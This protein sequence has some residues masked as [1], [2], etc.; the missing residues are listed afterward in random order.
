MTGAKVSRTEAAPLI[1]SYAVDDQ[2]L[3][4]DGTAVANSTV[5][6][7]EGTAEIGTAAVNAK[8]DWTFTTGTLADGSL[9]PDSNRFEIRHYQRG[10]PGPQCVVGC[11]AAPVIDSSALNSTFEEV[12]SGTAAANTTVAVF[13]AATELGTAAVSSNGTWRLLPPDTL[14]WRLRFTA[15]M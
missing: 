7:I 1:L 9:Q 14:E 11:P 13:E 4:L 15:R 2:V 6:I 3:T 8:G 5:A 10:L 12:L